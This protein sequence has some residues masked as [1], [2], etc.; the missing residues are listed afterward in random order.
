M[1]F[2]RK[3][4]L[5]F[6]LYSTNCR[7]DWY[8]FYFFEKSWKSKD[9][10]IALSAQS[11]TT[12]MFPI[13]SFFYFISIIFRPFLCR[14]SKKFTIHWIAWTNNDDEGFTNSTNDSTSLKRFGFSGKTGFSSFSNP[15]WKLTIFVAI[16]SLCV[17]VNL[18]QNKHKG[19]SSHVRYQKWRG[20][21]LSAVVVHNSSTSA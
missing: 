19:I 17:V 14:F 12:S 9:N 1:L 8:A 15:H 2:L 13:N 6:L 16:S 7:F 20:K 21:A 11:F 5:S 18:L 3:S 10:L 4:L